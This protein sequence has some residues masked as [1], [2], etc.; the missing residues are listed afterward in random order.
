MDYNFQR[1]LAAKRSVD[2][3]AIN[4]NVWRRLQDELHPIASG[5]KVN[6]L[7]IGMGTGAMFHRMIEWGLLRNAN[8]IGLDAQSENVNAAIDNMKSWA[9]RRAI[10][11]HPGSNGGVLEGQRVD[12]HCQFIVEDLFE[13]LDH[14]SHPQGWDVVVGQAFLDLIDVPDTLVR[15]KTILRPGGLAYFAI[16]YDG[17]TILEPSSGSHLDELIFTIYHQTMDERIV[18]NRRSGDSKTGRRLFNWFREAGFEILSAGPSD[19][20]VFANENRYP[21]DEKYFLTHILSFFEESLMDHPLIES[22]KFTGWL[23]E[24]RAQIESG[25]LVYI[26]HQIDFLTRVY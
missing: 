9:Q 4:L 25:E 21:A 17:L 26:A 16:N 20:V 15:L 19:W 18:K 14:Q 23:D 2:D 22:E 8:Y 12:I 11:Y 24:R 13:F 10:K 7:E 1:Y 3:R 6:I 5:K